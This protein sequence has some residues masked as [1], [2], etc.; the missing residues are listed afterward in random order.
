LAEVVLLRDL[1]G[2][3]VEETAAYLE[4]PQGTVKS[5]LHRA[6]LELA[7]KVTERLGGRGDAGPAVAVGAGPC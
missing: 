5:R 7:E 6:R 1:Q 2:W 4:V 3:S